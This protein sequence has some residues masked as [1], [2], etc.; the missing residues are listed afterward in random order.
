MGTPGA[1]LESRGGGE[2]GSFPISN[3]IRSSEKDFTAIP[4]MRPGS[5]EVLVVEP[6]LQIVQDA[7]ALPLLWPLVL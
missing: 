2:G 3:S 5:E 7:Y 6:K 1:K 4:M